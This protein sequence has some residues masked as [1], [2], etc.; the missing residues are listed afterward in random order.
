MKD[1]WNYYLTDIGI[2]F[3]IIGAA[4]YVLWLITVVVQ[5]LGLTIQRVVRAYQKGRNKGA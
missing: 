5:W 2:W 4:I 3:G 1:W